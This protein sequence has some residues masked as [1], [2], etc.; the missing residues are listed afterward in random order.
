MIDQLINRLKKYKK[1][2]GLEVLIKPDQTYVYQVIILEKKKNKIEI[3]DQ[4]QDLSDIS[5]IKKIEGISDLPIAMVVNGKSVL[6]KRILNINVAGDNPVAAVIPNANIEEFAYELYVSDQSTWISIIRKDLLETIIHSFSEEGLSVIDLS[7]GMFSVKNLLSLLPNQSMLQTSAFQLDTKEE[8]VIS[9]RARNEDNETLKYHIGED[10]LDDRLLLAF[11]KAFSN[12]VAI[13]KDI[14]NTQRVEKEEE[15]FLYTH[16][17]QK[18]KWVGLLGIFGLLLFNF[19]IFNY[20]NN[21]NQ[22]SGVQLSMHQNQLS[23]LRDLKTRY[24]EKQMFFKQ[25]SVL[26]PSKT[27]WY[28]DEIATSM[29]E[30][31]QLQQLEISPSINKKKRRIDQ[32]YLFDQRKLLI[33]G[34]SQKSNFLNSWINDLQALNWVE[35]VNVL[36]YSEEGN[37]RGEFELEVLLKD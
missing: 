37:G 17:F 27:S 6:N 28:A 20:L 24:Q 14:H 19:M 36:P 25:T 12:L 10:D 32:Q 1:V 21:K 8:E 34:K 30:G 31:I 7:I 13:P 11:S 35:T 4:Y 23:Q 16:L 9:F 3:I 18:T 26:K 15:T 29:Q 33:K 2:V 22:K 5:A